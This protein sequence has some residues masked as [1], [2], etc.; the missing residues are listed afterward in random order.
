M[1]HPLLPRGLT[2]ASQ[3]VS[4]QTI[5][6]SSEDAQLADVAGNGVVLVVTGYDLAE[7]CTDVGHA[8]MHSAL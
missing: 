5:Y 8:I 6:A 2:A 1:F 7:P 4:P 3:N